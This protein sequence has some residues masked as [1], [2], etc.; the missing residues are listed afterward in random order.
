MW[1]TFYFTKSTDTNADLFLVDGAVEMLNLIKPVG[2][3]LNP[4]VE[5]KG[6]Y[7]SGRTRS[8]FPKSM[9]GYPI[10]APTDQPLY[11]SGECYCTSMPTLCP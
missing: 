2:V 9:D 3:V 10:S 11:P 8:S 1:E 4:T 7:F 6:A 5:D